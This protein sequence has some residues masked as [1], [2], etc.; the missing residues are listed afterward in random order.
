MKQYTNVIRALA[1]LTFLVALLT[2]AF[3]LQ[4]SVPF[5]D[6]GEFTAAMTWQQV[7]HPPGA[8]LWLIVGRVMQL[9]IPFGELGWQANLA[10]GISGAFSS[11]LCFLII[12]KLV[13]RW[14]PFREGRTLIDYLPTFGG[15][16]IGAFAF[17]WSDSQWFNSVESEVYSPATFLA[18]LLVWLMLRWNEV[19]GEKGH[20]RYLLLMAYVIGL[21]IGT[22]LLA[23]LVF[24]AVAM[25]IYFR[26][27]EFSWV[28][29]AALMGITGLTFG[30]F[31]YKAP[32]EYIPKL[33]AGYPAIGVV[34]LAGVIGLA[35][36]AAVQKKPYV[37]VSAASLLLIV[38]GYTTYTQVLLRSN[39]NPPLNF[40]EPNS[41]SELVNYLGREQYGNRP[42][43]PRRV[44]WTE[45]Y[46]RYQDTY[47]DWYPPVDV[48][49]EGNL[50]FDKINTAGELNF[51]FSYQI[52][53]MY[54]RYLLWNF[55]G[56]V[57]DEYG[58]PWAAFSASEQER[59]EYID[60]TGYDDYF[61]VLFF[62]LPL[63]LGLFG[64]TYHYK[65]DWKMAFV[66]TTLFLFLGVLAALQQ[67]Q[68]QPQPRERD[69]F[70]AASFMIFAVWIGVGASGA[71][72]ALSN[73]KSGAAAAGGGNGEDDGIRELVKA[74]GGALSTVDVG[75]SR[76]ANPA[77]AAAVL[78]AL[79]L[80]VPIN[81]A[82]Q[83]WEMHDRSGNWVP[84][85][86]AYNILQS[87]D[88]DA[89]LFTN[90]DNDT[91]PVWFLQDVA[92]VRRDVRV[93]NLSLGQM[94]WY[95]KQLKDERPWGAKP[96]PIGF[97]ENQLLVESG[98]RGGLQEATMQPPTLELPVPASVMEW[99][100]DG[101]VNQP[102][103]MNWTYKGSASNSQD[104][105]NRYTIYHQLIRT[106][107]ETN[108]ANGWERPI[109][110]A[111]SIADPENFAGLEGFLR[112][113]GMAYRVMPV[114]QQPLEL[115]GWALDIDKVR[116]GLLN[117]LPADTFYT[118]PHRGY[119]FRN[120]ANPDVFYMYDH[121]RIPTGNYRL[122][123]LALARAELTMNNNPTGAIAALDSMDA[124][125]SNDIFPM[126]A[127][128][129]A[130]IAK[131]YEMAGGDKQ[132]EK[133]GRLTLTELD[134][135]KGAQL[136]GGGDPEL[137]RAEML[138]V[139]G[140]YDE[141]IQAYEALKQ[142][143][144]AQSGEI[145]RRIEEV[146]LQRFLDKDDMAGAKAELQKII[147]EYDSTDAT[148]AFNIEMLQQMLRQR[149][150]EPAP[151]A[152][153]GDEPSDEPSEATME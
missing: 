33:L 10:A 79:M 20:E 48:D 132:A 105:S 98:M 99:A 59:Q 133:Y 42:N 47:G 87:C 93:V 112:S 30:V 18:A 123:Y 13:E 150:G 35:A 127:P 25:V 28:S 86:Y 46:R 130:E 4:P 146:R 137:I 129:L 135:G 89:I 116:E 1:G 29:F 60:G 142:R 62:G 53:H 120:L 102:G 43:W 55:A 100:T 131:A 27:R 51:M 14:R 22:H 114:Q 70:Y 113:E 80:T 83:G 125:I 147:A 134:K 88:K 74:S 95:I 126:P 39:A 38:L 128:F 152:A 92:G 37:F 144:P 57:S 50:V 6:C 109:Y 82:L 69:Y 117:Q 141:S 149:T 54:V 8:P 143:Y 3:T 56:R 138:G 140:Q 111:N 21:A 58:S 81:M 121:R 101:K 68:Q 136:Q 110:F 108:A 148:A 24:P 85:D 72:D 66:F 49:A 94:A 9:I 106:I 76:V 61:P 97:D 19:A 40:G 122:V 145:R 44:E 65:R 23:L 139:V 41:F 153:P 115:F 107:V 11:M 63:L 26:H 118:E 84:W 119:K 5:W 52:G 16:L 91:F 31:I 71:A 17:I 36:W 12:V 104:G 78:G 67:Q 90:G 45:Y 103:V 151:D 77:I 34:L 32:L 7:Q 96:V 64:L 15:A 75:N 2:Y 73:R 124:W